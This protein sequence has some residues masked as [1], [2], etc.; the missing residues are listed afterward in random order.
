LSVILFDSQFDDKHGVLRNSLGLHDAA[1]LELHI[2]RLSF[3]RV[4]ELEE[5]PL[6]GAF[7][8]RY[9]RA[10]Q[11][12][13]FQDVFAWAGDFREVT[14]S[15]TKSFGFPPPQ[16]MVPSLEGIFGAVKSENYLQSLDADRFAARAGHYLGEINAVH[17]FREGNGRT[18]REFIRT[19]ALKAGHRLTWAG[20]T[21]EENNEA[22]R[23]SYATGNGEGLAA[24]IRKR[25]R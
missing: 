13:I 5:K 10:I 3:I 18:Q 21:P 7:D 17:P 4:A 22:S 8:I 9:L 12:Y 23:V 19:L 14:T 2:A 24:I 16:F 15:R 25:L 1:K 11:R 20:L 6:T